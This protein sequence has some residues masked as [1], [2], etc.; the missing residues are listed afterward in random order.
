MHGGHADHRVVSLADTR[1]APH[2]DS[3]VV[4]VCE[5]F[6]WTLDGLLGADG[7]C[8]AGWLRVEVVSAFEVRQRRCGC[9]LE[10]SHRSSAAFRSD[11]VSQTAILLLTT[12]LHKYVDVSAI[13]RY[14]AAVDSSTADA[15]LVVIGFFQL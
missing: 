3:I 8:K 15:T 12:I 2:L 9:H 6:L 7:L 11:I 14:A 5:A 13:R 1:V 4:R 10:G